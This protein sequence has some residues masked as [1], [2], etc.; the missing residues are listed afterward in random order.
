M[1]EEEEEEKKGQNQREEVEG[2]REAK[3]GA[4]NKQDLSLI[5]TFMS[6]SPAEMESRVRAAALIGRAGSTTPTLALSKKWPDS[7]SA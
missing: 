3:H 7:F 6:W 1:T 4:S 5:E 2:G